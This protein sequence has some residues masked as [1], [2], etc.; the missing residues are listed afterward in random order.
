MDIK[1]LTIEELK[2][3]YRE[4]K[5]TVREVVEYYLNRIKEGDGEINAFITLMEEEALKEA[6]ILD[7]RLQEGE[8]IGILGGIPI[9]VKDNICT[10]GVRTTCASKALE[11]FIPPYD[12]TVVKKLKDSG[13]IIIGKTNLDEFA[14]GSTTETSYFKAT[15][16][17][18]DKERVPGG[19]SGGSAA[20]VAAGFVPLALGSDTGGSIRQPAAFC[21]I[22]GLRPTYSLVS[23]YG[24]VSY[25][26]SFDQIGPMGKSVRDCAIALQVIQGNDPMD[27]TSIQGEVKKDYLKEMDKD[28]KGLKIGVIKECL[29]GDVDDEIAV[30]LKDTIERLKKMGAEIEEFSFKM[31]RECLS[32]YYIITSAEASSNM[33]RYDGILYGYRAEKYDNYEELMIKSRSEAFGKEV[34]LR[35]V[36]G[37]YVLT[38][39]NYDE[40]F[41]K[42][43]AA[44]R[45]VERLFKERFD[46]YDI[47][48]AP[49]TAGLP[50]KIGEIR[51]PMK[52][53]LDDVY[54]A[55][56]NIAGLPSISIPWGF[57]KDRLPIG[58]QLIG[59]RFR[60]DVL[61]RCAY[62]L[63]RD[64]NVF[65][66]LP[67]GEEI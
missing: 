23:R 55:T 63:E 66:N 16:N 49:T 6:D 57:S 3:G 67:E 43:L 25:A 60:E 48:L 53:Y 10:K 29:E 19:S 13:A 12:A 31:L 7:K 34:K 22:V 56:P 33:A 51:D 44:K 36:F 39:E 11:D 54:T 27:S 62:N 42:A 37:T 20:A 35:I 32:A 8:D 17:P 21:G 15:R 2:S 38:E 41:R 61:L 47:I 5:F 14:M 58:I 52:A 4:K 50:H 28:I 30:A 18:W 1:D 40:Y 65:G 26:S 24:L 45:K 64:L 46:R 9:A 59:D